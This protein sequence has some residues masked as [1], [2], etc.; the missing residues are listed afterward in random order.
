MAMRAVLWLFAALVAAQSGPAYDIVLRHGRVLDP[1][2]GLDGIRD[3]G[4]TGKKIT[5]LSTEPL[6]GRVEIDATGLVV[7]PGVIDLHS[8]GQTPENYHDKA[9]DVTTPTLELQ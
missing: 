9:M 2:S 7:A 1:A 6:R 3:V 5:A 8:H 4:I